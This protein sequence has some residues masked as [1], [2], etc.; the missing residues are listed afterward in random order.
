MKHV[1]LIMVT[2][3]NNNKYYKMEQVSESEWKATWGRVESTASDMMYPMRDWEKKY[4]EKTKK[5]YKD[6]THLK[7]VNE[8][9]DEAPASQPIKSTPGHAFLRTI[10]GYA[11]AAI[12]TNYS[13]SKEKVTKAMVDAA[14]G[15]VGQLAAIVASN[16]FDITETNKILLELYTTIP[17]KM[18]NVKYHILN[19]TSNM[20]D[21]QSMVNDEQSLL[22][23]MAGQVTLISTNKAVE[24]TPSSDIL[25][26]LG[27]E[28]IPATSHEIEMIKR[29]CAD[30]VSKVKMVF[31]VNNKKT[32][33]KFANV[34]T[35][36]IDKTCMGLFHGSRNQNWFNI[37]QSGLLIRPSCAV[38]TGSMFG[39]GVYFANKAQKS[40]GYSSFN[41]YWTRESANVGYIAVYD[42]HV[43]RQMHITNRTSEHGSLN[44]DKI[45]KNNFD[46]VYAHGGADLRNDEFIVYRPDQCT[47]KYLIELR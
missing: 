42:V 5:G 6:V 20:G 29:M 17:R 25:E 43:G 2:S 38:Y 36:E 41:G 45:I 31:A 47:I 8:S 19:D 16:T 27:L 39:D 26:Q 33:N 37:M 4:R 30:N 9:T 44:Y 46:S 22:D 32:R 13:V 35:K 7:V 10:M 28:I 3:D 12:T 24:S 21:L 18:K 15:L 34:L 11:N 14:Q 40:I 1:E 23:A